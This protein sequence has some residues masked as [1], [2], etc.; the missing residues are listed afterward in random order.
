M[1][2]RHFLML[3]LGGLVAVP[4]S[5]AQAQEPL[6]S[7]FLEEL[8]WME[9]RA[10]VSSGYTVALLP[11]GGTEQNGPHM[12]LGKHNVI[13]RHTAGEIARRLGGAL[14]APVVAYVPEGRLD[15]PEGH[16][17]FPGTLGVSDATFAALL[18]DA[19]TSLAAAGF[20]LICFLGDHGGSQ[21]V[22]EMVAMRLRGA[23]RRR[24]VH[25]AN[26]ARYYAANGQEDWLKA[27]GFDDAAIGQHA[28]LLDTAQLA[29]LA[30][31]DIRN[32]LLSPTA[33]PAGASGV[34]GD[35]SRATPEI[36]AALLDLKIAAGVAE[37]REIVAAQRRG[38]R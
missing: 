2:R 35:P 26:L 24:G 38:L 6:R 20:S 30:P 31:N 19:A 37:V 34:M 7:V 15:P 17:T 5:R 22:Q 33:W 1:R 32:A 21:M 9:L 28:G 16:M 12:A 11:T 36:G 8:T 23:W 10:A 29:A 13:V 3:G 27:Q 25:V 14:V 4:M 18:Q